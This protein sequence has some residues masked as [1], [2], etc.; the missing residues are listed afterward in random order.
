LSGR[1][2]SIDEMRKTT[3]AL[4]L[5]VFLS[6]LDLPL[7]AVGLAFRIDIS[8]LAVA[9]VVSF[10]L[11]CLLLRLHPREERRDEEPECRK[12]PQN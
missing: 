9:T 7:W 3:A 6:L 1:R 11:A 10:A 2:V 4:K 12:R 5:F 8:E